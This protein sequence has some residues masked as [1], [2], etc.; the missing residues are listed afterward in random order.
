MS[1][2]DRHMARH[3]RKDE[4]AGGE[5][6]GVIETRKKLWR[7]TD[8]NIVSKRPGEPDAGKTRKKH[9]TESISSGQTTLIDGY[10]TR[11][12]PSALHA[13]PLSPPRSMMSAESFERLSQQLPVLADDHDFIE[14]A[15]GQDMLDF[16]ANASWGSQT[17]ASLNIQDD[18]PL[19]DLF[20]PDTGR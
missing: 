6:L 3:R 13:E 5:G 14:P 20:N 1:F 11:M 19:D 12:A 17:S 7:D 10:G 2:V 16:L 4:E 9:A 8:G 18:M 15:S